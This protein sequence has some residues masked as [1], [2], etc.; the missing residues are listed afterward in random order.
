MPRM[1]NKLDPGQ[2]LG[3]PETAVSPKLAAEFLAI[4]R[5]EG[6]RPTDPAPVLARGRGGALRAISMPWGW[7]RAGRAPQTLARVEHAT[8]G[9]WAE[10]TRRRRC[11][12]PLE[13]FYEYAGPDGRKIPWK[14]SPRTPGVDLWAAGIWEGDAERLAFA[15]FTQPMPEAWADVHER[16]AALL[17]PDQVLPWLDGQ[18]APQDAA[19]AVPDAVDARSVSGFDPFLPGLS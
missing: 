9:M 10:A 7:M 15:L 6:V 4:P 14:F 13:A 19:G 1:C 2:G 12:V 3:L 11:A 8:H 17:T 5:R 18:L 16:V